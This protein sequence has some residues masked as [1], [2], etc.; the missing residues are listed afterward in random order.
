MQI[1]LWSFLA[2]LALCS[3]FLGANIARA[4]GDDN[5]DENVANCLSLDDQ[6]SDLLIS[7]AVDCYL[8]PDD[9][10][11]VLPVDIGFYPS[12]NWSWYDGGRRHHHRGHHG[13]HGHHHRR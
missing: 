6:A 7:P 2:P 11:C 12:Y 10:T 1:K 5:D 4:E 8:F 9:P 13:H 3:L